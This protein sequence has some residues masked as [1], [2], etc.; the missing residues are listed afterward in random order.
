VF[1]KLQNQRLLYS[2]KNFTSLVCLYNDAS[3]VRT[4]S[5]FLFL[6]AAMQK[7]PDAKH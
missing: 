1:I 4:S 2:L 7:P 3:I 5:R 6:L